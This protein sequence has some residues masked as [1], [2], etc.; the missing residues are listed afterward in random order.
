MS[1]QEPPPEG[2]HVAAGVGGEA[3]VYFY[4]LDHGL[5]EGVLGCRAEVRLGPYATLDE[6]SRALDSARR[7][8]ELWD[9]AD[10]EWDNGPA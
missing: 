7:R 5:V 4:C 1:P 9:S 8:T 3:P 2:E 10:D 6:A